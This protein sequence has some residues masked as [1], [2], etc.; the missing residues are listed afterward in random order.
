VP[1]LQSLIRI[2]RRVFAALLGLGL[3]ACS[4]FRAGPGIV[5]EQVQVVG[6]GFAL[7]ITLGE[8]SQLIRTCAWRQTITY[9]IRSPWR[10]INRL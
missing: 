4:L 8:L 6:W 2:S 10:R 1:K 5:W 7:I 3:L 9:D